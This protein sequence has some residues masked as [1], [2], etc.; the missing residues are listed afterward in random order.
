VWRE[1]LHGCAQRTPE[2]SGGGPGTGPSMLGLPLPMSEQ[3]RICPECGRRLT[4]DRFG[5]GRKRCRDCINATQRRRYRERLG[6]V[7]VQDKYGVPRGQG[8]CG[9]SPTWI[10]AA[11]L[12]G[13]HAPTFGAARAEQGECR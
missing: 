6:G 1:R 13:D 12:F 8:G 4:P 10:P 3:R 2:R 9:P 5:A 7:D 11:E